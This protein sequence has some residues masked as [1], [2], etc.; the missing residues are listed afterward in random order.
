MRSNGDEQGKRSFI[1]EARRAQIVSCAIDVI[2]EVGYAQASLAKIAERAGISKGVISYHF[3]GKDEL[4]TQVAAQVVANGEAALMPGIDAA[5]DAAGKLGAF[6]RGNLAFIGS[7][8][9]QLLAL[10]EIVQNLRHS[11]AGADAAI[12][13]LERILRFGQRTGEFRKFSTHVMATSIRAALDAVSGQLVRE[14]DLDL[15]AYADELVDLFLSATR[16]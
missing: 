7:S 13:G 5:E 14:P 2:A 9:N 16:S 1:E 12:A 11:N 6:I 3:A 8:R 10:V 4:I 15:D